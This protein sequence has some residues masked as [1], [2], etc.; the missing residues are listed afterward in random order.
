M[1]KELAAALKNYAYCTA[2][3]YRDMSS[4]NYVKWM[5]SERTLNRL[6]EELPSKEP[7]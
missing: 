2:L 4:N 1:T 6:I 3:Y 5:E 7:K